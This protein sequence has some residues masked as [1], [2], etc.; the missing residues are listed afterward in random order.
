MNPLLAA[1]LF[2]LALGGMEAFAWWTHKYI[3]H[4][5]LW[6]LHRSHHQRRRG[7]FEANDLFAVIFA[8]PAIALIAI[9]TW[10]W[11]PGL[12]LGLGMTAYG[13]VYAIFHDGLVHR[14]YPVPFPRSWLKRQVQA[15]RLHHA[16]SEKDGA[17]SFGFLWAPPVRELKA[18][19][20]RTSL[21]KPEPS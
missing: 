6:S 13:A 9:G 20:D 4:G 10:F 21:R 15:H 18:R 8:A 7:A 12:W 11:E 5:P 17:V 19:V 2:F 3:M 14:R 16:V 1:L